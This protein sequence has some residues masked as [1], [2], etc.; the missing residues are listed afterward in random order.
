MNRWYSACKTGSNK[1]RDTGGALR[2]SFLSFV[3]KS[4]MN[5]PSRFRPKKALVYVFL[6]AFGCVFGT[7]VEGGVPITAGG[8]PGRLRDDFGMIFDGFWSPFGEPRGALWGSFGRQSL[9]PGAFMSIFRCFV[10]VSKKGS[11]KVSKVV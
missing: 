9:Q 2:I 3:V 4:G 5:T 7:F 6:R 11:K 10:G 1:Y 8:S